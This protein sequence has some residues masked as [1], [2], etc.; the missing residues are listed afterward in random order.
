MVMR[1]RILSK[2]LAGALLCS[3][4]L[5]GCASYVDHTKQ[6]RESVYNNQYDEALKRLEKSPIKTQS[7]NRLLYRL[8]KSTILDRLGKLKASRKELL[9]ADRIIDELYTES[10]SRGAASFLV[11]D[12]LKEYAG[13]DYEKVAVHTMLA[14]SFLED[15]RLTSARVEAKKINSRLRDIVDKYGDSYTKYTQDAFALF[16]SGLIFEALGEYDEA[17]IDY[18]KSL[19]TYESGFLQGN[20]VPTSLVKSL[21]V[22]A[23]RR[24]RDKIIKRLKDDYS[25]DVEGLSDLDASII[26]IGYGFPVVPK[27]SKSFILNSGNGILRYSWPIIPNRFSP[28]PDFGVRF[29]QNP[30][31]LELGQDL[32]RIARSTLESNRLRMTVKNVARLIAKASAAKEIERRAGPLAGFIANIFAAATETADTRSWSLLAGRMYIQRVFVSPGQR[33]KLNEAG[34]GSLSATSLAEK[35]IKFVILKEPR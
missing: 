15:N 13:E 24:N 33:F 1:F 34:A 6:L 11:N 30:V 7:R 21:Y 22:C 9:E 18:K 19:K 35:K 17:I 5:F 4:F 12:D 8:E 23:L 28:E 32:N 16:I 2:K 31:A 14:M 25:E 3:S 27:Q 10:I 20:M 29:N 26:F